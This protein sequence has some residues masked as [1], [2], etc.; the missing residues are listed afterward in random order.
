MHL[1]RQI[2]IDEIYPLL[3]NVSHLF[4]IKGYSNLSNPLSKGWFHAAM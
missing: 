1:H 2:K 3:I 4:Q